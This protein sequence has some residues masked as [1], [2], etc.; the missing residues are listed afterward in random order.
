MLNINL[1]IVVY[2]PCDNIFSNKIRDGVALRI[3]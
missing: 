1:F 2:I 3:F